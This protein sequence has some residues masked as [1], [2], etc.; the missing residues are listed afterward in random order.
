MGLVAVG[1]LTHCGAPAEEGAGTG[2]GEV[3]Q[4]VASTLTFTPVADASVQAASPAQNFGTGTLLLSDTS[5]LEESYLRFSVAGLSGTVTSARLRLYV[6]NGTSNGPALHPVA[7]GWTETGVTWNTRPSRTG[8]AVANVGTL[9]AGTFVEY[10]VTALVRGNG[11]YDLALVPETSDG[12]DFASR[13]SSDASRRPQLVLTVETASPDCLPRTDT[14]PLVQ[15]VRNDA[16]VSQDAPTTSFD[17]SGVLRADG[18]PRLEAFLRFYVEGPAEEDGSTIRSARL[19]LYVLDATSDAPALYSTTWDGAPITWE[20]RPRPTGGVVANLGAIAA[21][22]WVEY[23]VTTA[24]R[25]SGIH[26]FA[27]LPESTNGVDFASQEYRE[28]WNVFPPQLVVIREVPAYCSY[29][30]TG[31]GTTRTV[32]QHGGG[33]NE[34]VRTTAAHPQGG[35]VVVGFTAVGGSFGGTS[36]GAAG[37]VLARYG[38]DGTHLWSRLVAQG[39]LEPRAM[40]IT[41]EGNVLVVGTYHGTPDFGAGPLPLAKRGMFLA[42]FAPDGR[43]VW[44]RGFKATYMRDELEE[45]PIFPMSV[46]T[47]AQ[48]SLIVGG[49][50][51]GGMDL[52]GGRLYAGDA[53]TAYDDAEPGGFVARFSWDGKHLWS[54]AFEGS[55][56]AHDAQVNDVAAD[57]QGNVYVAG[58]GGRETDLGDGVKGGFN[59]FLAKY[60]PEGALVWKRG[61][62]GQGTLRK[63]APL[64]GGRVLFLGNFGL[65]F[66]FG[67]RT[68]EA[69]DDYEVWYPYLGALEATGSDAWI[70]RENSR[71]PAHLFALAEGGWMITGEVMGES[72]LGGGTLGSPHLFGGYDRYQLLPYAARYR[73]DG[74]HVWSR[75]FDNAFGTGDYRAPRLAP[76]ARPDGT[77]V[78]GA[79]VGETVTV[80]GR[81]FSPRGNTDVL[82]LQLAP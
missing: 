77:L 57:A 45:W 70:Q 27:L 56:G 33:A 48:G 69:S 2:E 10:D 15:Y 3:R 42:K 55:F 78:L 39:G 4:E 24:V 58:D 22:T 5:P 17:T 63:V 64:A 32:R 65:T 26:S 81:D 11:T 20:S 8:A 49:S 7:G 71:R 23:D 6:S 18:S 30:G 51:H 67:G 25:T 31:G 41:P 76:A 13:E 74:S 53:S 72:D 73:A 38:A 19:R 35:A 28:G 52:G 46:A 21:G 16:D 68:Y 47:N 75:T 29:R 60:S 80:D 54:R 34:Q 59:A 12:V 79:N 43:H 66:T 61:F 44:S 50:F 37:M 1:L 9:G 40:T 62:D 36:F 82:M 14:Y